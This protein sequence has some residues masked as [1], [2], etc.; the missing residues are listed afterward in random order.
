MSTFGLGFTSASI[1]E[2]YSSDGVYREMCTE[3]GMVGGGKRL[4]K[5]VLGLNKT[6]LSQTQALG[7]P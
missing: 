6:P 5:I 2:V 4:E 7:V 1:L 3:V